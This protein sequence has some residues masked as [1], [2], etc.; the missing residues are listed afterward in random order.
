MEEL[1]KNLQALEVTDLSESDDDRVLKRS[2]HALVGKI[3]GLADKL[4]ITHDG[5]CDW[6]RIEDLREAGYYV[7]CGE[8]DRFGWLTG[9]IQTKKGIVVYG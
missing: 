8:Q 6:D 1:I 4:L 5:Q 9:C 2:D 7:F 3:V